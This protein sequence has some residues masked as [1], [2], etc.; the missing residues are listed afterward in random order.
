MTVPAVFRNLGY[1]GFGL[2]S[3]EGV[4][5]P[6]DKFV[7]F[8]RSSLIPQQTVQ[9]YPN[10]N[11][12]D[13]TFSLKESMVYAGN[14][15]SLLF[16]DEGGALMAWA[17]G[18]DSIS[19]MSDPYTH[20][21]ELTDNLPFV[22]C[23]V[24]HA[25]GQLIDR[26]VDGKIN[27]FEL[28]WDVPG[29]ALIGNFD[30]MG[31]GAERQLS[32]STPTFNDAPTEGPFSFLDCVFTITGPTDAA[33]MALQIQKG[34]IRITQ[35]VKAIYGPGSL[36]PIFLLE[37]N[38]IVTAN[39]DVMLSSADLYALTY[40]GANAGTDPS[41]VIGT[42]TL[43][44]K[45]SIAAA[46]DERSIDVVIPAL[47]WK[48]ATPSGPDPQAQAAVL[49]VQSTALR[50]GDVLPITIT[51]K[52]GISSSYLTPPTPVVQILTATNPIVDGDNDDDCH[53]TGTKIAS[54]TVQV[55]AWDGTTVL[56]PFAVTNDTATTWHV[57][58]AMDLST[59]AD[60]NVVYVATASVT[61]DGAVV[62]DNYQ[63]VKE[64]AP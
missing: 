1:I 33:V 5:V 51:V 21:L 28:S 45:A 14:V 26:L 17:M 61:P 18:S 59:L 37:T 20:L 56:G 11:T 38:R 30:F 58:S 55:W 15:E 63:A 54:V 64:A 10:G 3:A 39:F 22:T 25:D 2:Q 60:G 40:Y 34:S 6:P 48:V 42:G 19:G 52:N 4:A 27:F 9:D 35:N 44:L 23:E 13:I 49:S 7:K 31:A 57:T 62:H 46:P 29:K 41:R 36:T 50:Q 24:E 43:E 47:N 12:R 32:A 8:M 16:A 53:A